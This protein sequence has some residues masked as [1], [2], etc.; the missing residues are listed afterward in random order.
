MDI[1]CND[2]VTSINWVG[3]LPVVG[4]VWYHPNCIYNILS[5]SKTSKDFSITY[6]I[7][8]R[9]AFEVNNPYGSIKY[10][11]ESNH[12]LLY[13]YINNY[14]VEAALVTYYSENT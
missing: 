12:G 13:K 14:H 3:D 2:G 4:H 7:W 8:V 9:N 6:Y 1:H 5:L 10:F 11:V